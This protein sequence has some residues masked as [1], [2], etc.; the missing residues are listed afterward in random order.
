MAE[1]KVELS[2]ENIDKAI[3]DAVINSMLGKTIIEMVH[4]KVKDIQANGYRNPISDIIDQCI[5]AEIAKQ[6]EALIPIISEGVKKQLT[7]EFVASAVQ[8]GLNRLQQDRY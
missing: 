3:A 2:A 8:R 1:V 7:E 6:V 5:R 4:Q